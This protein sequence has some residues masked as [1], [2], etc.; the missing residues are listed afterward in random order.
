MSHDERAQAMSKEEIVALLVAYEDIARQNAWF[1]QQLFGQKSE[2]RPLDPDA[3]QLMLG[4]MPDGSSTPASTTTVAA[5]SR[6]K[7][8]GRNDDHA[9]SLR[10][11]PS[12]PVEEVRLPS[13]ALDQ[14]HEVV[15]EKI[16]YRL[17]QRPVSYVVLKYIRPVVKR[18]TDG[19]LISTPAPASPLGKSL[20]DVSLLAS[21]AIEKF[22]YHLPLYRQH[23]RMEAAG[24]HL[25]R[26]TLTG[27]IH[28]SGD[29]LEPIYE[30]Q[31]ASVL[32]SR[33]IAMDETPIKAGVQGPGKMRTGYFWPMYGDQSEVVFPF[34]PTRAA[35]VVTET[36]QGFGGV[37][38][39]DGYSAY[40]RYAEQVRSVVH[41]QCWSHTRRQ[42]LQAEQVEPE[43]TRVALD[44][45][46]R[47]YE[48]EAT[49][50][51]K[52]IDAPKR[53]EQRALHSRPIVDGF[54]EWLKQTL[55]ER[56]LLPRNPF[57]AAAHYTLNRERAL[58]VFLEHAEVPIDTN[59]LER[60]IRPI[61]LG[62]KNW[63]F[64][65]SEIGARYV[66]I[67]QSLLTTCRLHGVDPYVYLVDVLQRV[68]T[69]PM[70]EVALL[71]PRLWKQHIAANPLRSAIDRVVKDGV[72]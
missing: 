28:R 29:L 16:S 48:T 43:L 20:A 34:A 33:V 9:E 26:S 39:S 37:L 60:Q 61:A 11:D 58:R 30:S 72:P 51:A 32:D 68:E 41:A 59:H 8:Q 1:K 4:E 57:T 7:H 27:L 56:L 18:K 24:I 21:M 10:F 64:C 12:V 3:R 36:L 31:L 19:V 50:R 67:F 55:S 49:L 15:S 13:P 42:F 63:L 14:E 71:S 54:F 35:R 46:R 53:L 23:Q 44:Q 69:H 22:L 38:V 65:W 5:H 6:R 40:E 25:A 2:R 45:I 47:L 17:A 66:G 70:S 52:L 62:R